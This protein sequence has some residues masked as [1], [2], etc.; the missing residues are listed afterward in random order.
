[1]NT[2]AGWT[3]D[4]PLSCPWRAFFDPFVRRVQ[5]AHRAFESGNL[6]ALVP[7]MSHRLAEGVL[8]YDAALNRCHA[9]RMRKEAE[10]RRRG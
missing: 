6:G 5:A 3:G 7:N 9:T 2:V 8:H 4:R 10:E 1:M